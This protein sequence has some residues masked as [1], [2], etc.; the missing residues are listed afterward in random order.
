MNGGPLCERVDAVWPPW[1][2]LTGGIVVAVSWIGKGAFL[3][4]SS[5]AAE[6]DSSVHFG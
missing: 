6:L 1:G 3:T 4:A 2:E 5:L